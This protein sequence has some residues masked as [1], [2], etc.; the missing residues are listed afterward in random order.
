MEKLRSPPSMNQFVDVYVDAV[1]RLEQKIADKDE[2]IREC[3]ANNDQIMAQMNVIATEREPD[4]KKFVIRV[5][6]INGVYCSDPIFKLTTDSNEQAIVRFADFSE[7]DVII[8]LSPTNAS[9]EVEVS[10]NE[11]NKQL[12][13]FQISI[14]EFENRQRRELEVVGPGNVEPIIIIYEGQLIYNRQDYHKGFLGMN[15]AKMDDLK[16]FKFQYQSMQDQL[17]DLFKDAALKKSFNQALATK[18]QPLAIGL[19][20]SN[21]ANWNT[22]PQDGPNIRGSIVRNLNNS[23]MRIVTGDPNSSMNRNQRKD[24]SRDAVP[25]KNAYKAQAS[26]AVTWNPFVHILFYVNIGLLTASFFVNWHRAS[27]LSLIVAIV[28]LTWYLQKED[29]EQLL[30]PLFLAVGY[31]LALTFDLL[32]LI[33]DSKDVWTKGIWVHSGS[34][35]GMDKFMVIMSYILF[36]FE[37]AALGISVLLHFSGMFKNAADKRT[38]IDFQMKI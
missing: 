22:N 29:Y 28:F 27:F 2:K 30:P 14:K 9:I 37:G 5:I 32:W 11:T 18:N 17:L 26:S 12:H 33:Q 34:L 15:R 6:E 3:M 13:R 31:A 36:G 8:N 23:G 24:T 16:Q 7:G 10:N 38:K 25:T 20:Q 35:A 1:S 21:P 4:A 19:N